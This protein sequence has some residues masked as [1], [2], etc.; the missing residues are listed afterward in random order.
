LRKNND[1]QK[2]HSKPFHFTNKNTLFSVF[3]SPSHSGVQVAIQLSKDK[4]FEWKLI[5]AELLSA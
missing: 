3:S 4:S 1:T 2:I 5:G